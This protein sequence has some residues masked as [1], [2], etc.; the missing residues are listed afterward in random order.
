MGYALFLA[1]YHSKEE[2][3]FWKYGTMGQLNNKLKSPIATTITHMSHCPHSLF[4]VEFALDFRSSPL[5]KMF[6][7]RCLSQHAP[8]TFMS[9][10]WCRYACMKVWI[11]NSC[12][13]RHCR[14]TKE[15]TLVFKNKNIWTS[16]KSWEMSNVKCLCWSLGHAEQLLVSCL[17]SKVTVLG[18]NT[19][20]FFYPH[21][22]H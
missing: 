4:T 12:I 11:L 8:A 14:A 15:S 16:D 17:Y 7:L 20:G 3:P 21:L 9:S 22:K 19:N 2:R 18:E 5:T 13:H 1:M 10:D 6:H